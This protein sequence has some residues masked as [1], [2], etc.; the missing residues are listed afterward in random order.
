MTEDALSGVSKDSLVLAML[1]VLGGERTEVNERDLFLACWHA[2]PNTMRWVDTAL[3]NPDTF[4]ASLRRLD[5]RGQIERL[6]KQE[7][8][9]GRSRR[10]K[11]PIDAGRSGVVKARIP[12]GGLQSAGLSTELV[13]EVRKLVPNPD[14]TRSLSESALIALCVGLR[15]DLG[16]STDE[17]ALVELAFHKFPERF[18]YAERPEF[19][20]VGLIR[21][22]VQTAQR[23]GL[24]DPHYRLTERGRLAVTAERGKVDV[25]VD[26]TESHKA[27][28]LKFADRIER[29]PGYQ[30]YA[31]HGTLVPTKPDELFRALRVAPTTNPRPVANALTARV[32]ALRRIDKAQV[33]SYLVAL[34]REHNPEVAEILERG[35]GLEPDAA[36]Q[37]IAG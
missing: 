10:R 30:A 31:E 4:T 12:E 36:A 33:A 16:W 23:E 1:A 29:T 5:K 26:M 13:D 25:R 8:Q 18:S 37:A 19:P 17:G 27:G 35:Q 11:S 34:A 24:I 2:F 14:A 28:D 7:R 15:D 20:D 32:A 9:K 22:A 6:G 21:A 3:P